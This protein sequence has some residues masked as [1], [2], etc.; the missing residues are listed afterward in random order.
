MG[1]IWEYV[2]KLLAFVILC[3]I[4]KS[5]LPDGGKNKIFNLIIGGIMTILILQP[6]LNL[7]ETSL[8]KNIKSDSFSIEPDE[9]M[10]DLMYEKMYEEHLN[11]LLIDKGIQ[12]DSNVICKDKKVIRVQVEIE[13]NTDDKVTDEIE[14]SILVM[15]DIDRRNINV[16]KI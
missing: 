10:E 15:F 11:K 1:Y 9:K 7:T 14:E 2:E 4:L 6:I 13:K 3:N 5:I 8:E 16:R 12:G